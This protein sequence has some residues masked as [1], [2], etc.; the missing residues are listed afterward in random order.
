MNLLVECDLDINGQCAKTNSI[1]DD[2]QRSRRIALLFPMT[3]PPSNI[4]KADK[5]HDNHRFSAWNW[6]VL[7]NGTQSPALFL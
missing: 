3:T 6:Y 1:L 5:T 2:H 7:K 4:G